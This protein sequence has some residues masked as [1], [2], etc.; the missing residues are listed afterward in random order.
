M[1]RILIGCAMVLTIILAAVLVGFGPDR[2]VRTD[3]E[4]SEMI[5]R[6]DA[7]QIQ[8]TV[9]TLANTFT[10]QSCSDSPA[11]GQG[12]TAAREFIFSKYSAIPGLQVVR[13]PF[14]HPKCSNA[15]TFN[16]IAWKL[17]ERHPERLV[18]VGG[19]YDS[20]TINVFDSSSFAPAANDAGAQTGV[21]LEVARVIGDR[22]LENTVVFMSFSGEEQGLYGSA[23]IA[24]NLAKYFSN[25]Q[26]FAMLNT[27]IP[28]GNNTT[29]LGDDLFRFRLYS[30][31]IPREQFT[32][33]PDGTTDNTS[34]SRGLM[35]YVAT[36]GGA[37]VPS[38]TPKI[39][40]RQD[41]PGR[42]SDHISFINQGDPAVR[43]METVECSPSPPDN[44]CGQ[45][46]LPC[47]TPANIPDD[48]K[49]FLTAHQHTPFDLPQYV[50]PSYAAR[51]AQVI[52]A[53]A[54]SLA[55][56]PI[57][58]ANFNAVGDAVNGV[59]VSFQRTG[60]EDGV[61]HFVVAARPV[62]E[63]L[64]HQRIRLED[65]DHDRLIR[66]ERLGI[67]PGD[68]FFISVAAVDE[69]GHESLFAFPEVR[70]DSTGC[71]VPAGV[72]AAMAPGAKTA[73]EF[74]DVDDE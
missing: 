56:A 65:D 50:T 32:T 41:R 15:P 8:N 73:K 14:A 12:V 55:S 42:G 54:A 52:A 63:N 30:P 5:S 39:E 9:N 38:M 67:T 11:P 21:V 61:D 26:V 47:P 72:A 64:Y 34:P 60:E 17:G 37:Y 25:P 24:P 69:R 36:W 2:S 29:T 35:R 71:A 18:I 44:S 20:R 27:D 3:R 49:S 28:G 62:T 43:I 1:N 7:S 13:D 53:S 68:A 33:D 46:P 6:I 22:R 59:R 23:S 31:G 16:V 40:L 48:C 74:K 10:H 45:L 70:C 66:P 4:I 51:I 19:H 58:P 57:A